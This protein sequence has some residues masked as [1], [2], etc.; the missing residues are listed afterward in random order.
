LKSKKRPSCQCNSINVIWSQSW[1]GFFFHPTL[2][3]KYILMILS[4]NSVCVCVCLCTHINGK[5]RR[6]RQ[7][8]IPGF[9]MIQCRNRQTFSI[10]GQI[11]IFYV[12]Q[13]LQSVVATQLG[14]CSRKA[15]IDNT[16]KN[17]CGE[18]LSISDIMPRAQPIQN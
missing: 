17:V 9:R 4:S 14:D 10:S 5:K 3:R 6:K 18:S 12:L 16:L 8:S 2:C 1:A 7:F 11:V 13:V 15:E